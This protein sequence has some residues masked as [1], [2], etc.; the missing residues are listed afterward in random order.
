MKFSD[1][2]TFDTSGLTITKDGY[3]EVNA[4]TART[5]IQRYLGVELGRPDLHVVNVYRDEAEVFSS[6]SLK[7]FSKIPITND[8]PATGVNASNWK[9]LAVGVTGDEVLRDGEYLKIGLKITDAQAVQIV[10]DGK[11]ELS[12]GYSAD[13]VWQDGIA[14]D[15]SAYQAVQKN[16]M[17]NHIAIVEYARAG[18]QARIGDSWRVSP[19]QDFKP[20]VLPTTVKGDRMSDQLKTVVLGDSVIQIAVSDVAALE[21]FKAEQ[22]KA[23]NDQKTAHDVAIAAKDAELAKAHAERDEAKDKVLDANALDKLVQ[24]RADL[25]NKAKTIADGI[26]TE[27]LTD[28]EIK[29]VAVSQVRGEDSI[30]DKS[31]AYIDATFDILADSVQG[32]NP[33]ADAIKGTTT[34][35]LNDAQAAYV[36]RLTR[37]QTKEG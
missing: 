16:I 27:G 15:G 19:V 20:G 3:L 12:V 26:K 32:A 11:R 2:L 6:R 22:N 7:T 4:R 35:P 29:R 5:G 18:S 36:D 28:T 30:K 33:V 1:N 9:D 24:A 37:Q 23:L 34:N 8:H 10:Q 25:I 17:A 21:R 13:I 31:T 14:P